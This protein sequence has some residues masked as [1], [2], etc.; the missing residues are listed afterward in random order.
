MLKATLEQTSFG[1]SQASAGVAGSR[2]GTMKWAINRP[3]Q[4]HLGVWWLLL[5]PID[6]QLIVPA[7]DHAMAALICAS[8]STPAPSLDLWMAR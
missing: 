8:F 2:A 4:Q 3:A 1:V 6:G 7:L 5:R